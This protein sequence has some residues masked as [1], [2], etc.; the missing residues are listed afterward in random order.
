VE[1]TFTHANSQFQPFQELALSPIEGFNRFA[2][3]KALRRFKVQGSRVQ[4][5]QEWFQVAFQSFQRSSAALR[6]KSVSGDPRHAA[7]DK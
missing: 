1:T 2:P 7:I 6:V 5:N 4:R 3:F